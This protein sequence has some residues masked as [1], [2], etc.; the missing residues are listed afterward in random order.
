[1]NATQATPSEVRQAQEKLHSEG[2]YQGRIDGH[3]GPETQQAL[4]AYQQKNG[5]QATAKLDQETM[6]S[7]LGAGA[8]AGQGSSMP[9]TPSPSS[10]AGTA[11]SGASNWNSTNPTNSTK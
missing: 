1:M 6:N 9:S 3:M 2:L 8:G 11:G 4:R 7:L 10:G 5:L